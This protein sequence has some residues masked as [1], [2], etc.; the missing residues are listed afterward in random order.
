MANIRCVFFDKEIEPKRCLD[1]QLTGKAICKN[2]ADGAL[3]KEA[4]VKIKKSARNITPLPSV[5][6]LNLRGGKGELKEVKMKEKDYSGH[7]KCHVEGCS[8]YAVKDGKCTRCYNEAHGI[9]K[10]PGRKPVKDKNKPECGL[11]GCSEAAKV[12]G[13]C[14]KHYLR[15]LI[16]DGRM[17]EKNK[18]GSQEERRGSHKSPDNIGTS[19][20]PAPATKDIKEIPKDNGNYII[21]VDFTSY[22]KL[23]DKLIRLADEDFRTPGQQLLSMLHH[24]LKDAEART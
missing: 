13:L 5:S 18:R 14:S 19:S 3:V 4:L 9:Q 10:R 1:M 22:P 12:K 16:K 24:T 2:C 21:S 15:K 17:I 6:P 7:A 23:H 8:K 20:S 11:D